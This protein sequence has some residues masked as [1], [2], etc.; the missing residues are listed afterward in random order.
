MKGYRALRESAAWFDISHRGKIK[1]SGADRVHFIHAMS[2]ND[3]EKL[4]PGEGIRT[5]FLNGQG[6]ILAEACVFAAPDHLLLDCHGRRRET[7]RLHLN[8]FIVMDDVALEDAGSSLASIAVE[9]PRA[10]LV[11][12]KVA[13]M[14]PPGELNHGVDG[15]VT[16]ARGSLTGGPGLWLFLPPE[17]KPAWAARLESAGAFPAGE[18]AWRTVR[19]ENGVPL[20]G[21]DYPDKTIP[22]QA[23]RMQ[24]V[25]FTKGCYL[26]QEIVERVRSRGH[27]HRALEGLEV[28]SS[29]LPA[30]D[31]PVIWRGKEVGRLTSPVF[32]PTKGKVLAFALLRR[33]AVQGETLTVDGHEARV[34]R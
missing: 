10:E 21:V 11:V 16:I 34:R 27:V 22:Q 24:A 9:G 31:S 30:P 13:R 28:D 1:V 15:S 2:T 26:G 23:A 12:S 20:E 8:K 17:E 32:S 33:E 29:E 5:L 14:P 19:V 7:L 6:H 18:E 3:I 4:S 25:S